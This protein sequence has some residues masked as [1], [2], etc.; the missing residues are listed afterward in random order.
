MN[1]RT[2]RKNIGKIYLAGGCF[3]G[4]EGYF[5][6]LDGVLDTEVGY[7]NGK[8]ENPTYEDVCYGDTN[9]AE[10][11]AI[12]YDRTII[13][14]EELLLHY[15]RIIN[16][17]TVNRQG[18]DVGRQY[19][20]GIYFE[21]QKDES[22]IRKLLSIIPDSHNFA[23]EIKALENFYLA[24]DYHQDYLDKN[25]NGYCHI[26]LS[27]AEKPLLSDI[28][29]APESAIS[30]KHDREKALVNRI[31]KHA[32]QITQ[33]AA[34]EMA[35]TGKYDDFWEKGIY[36]DVVS[37][38]PLFSSSDKYISGC[39]WP[40]FSRPIQWKS[41]KYSEDNS[42]GMNRVEVKGRGSDSH[43][44]HVFE[45]GLADKGGLRYCINSASLRFVPLEDM[46]SEGYGEYIPLVQ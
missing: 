20:T 35:F 25:P 40:A 28:Y 19:R 34:T 11:V 22:I 3:W 2:N 45:D 44:G 42:H 29:N 33:N 6:R 37:G 31:G 30:S 17:Y 16:P 15:L 18:N 9:H 10:T 12:T 21:N 4:V 32:Y 39:G 27:M 26:N 23:I 41:V 24:E 46:E 1:I 14:L 36:V 13:S 8:T 5:K 43:L 38:E 7:A